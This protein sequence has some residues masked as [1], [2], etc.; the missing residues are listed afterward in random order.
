[1]AEPTPERGQPVR[2][3]IGGG[4][5]ALGIIAMIGAV[6]AAEGAFVGERQHRV[7]AVIVGSILM[8]P[9]GSWI[10]WGDRALTAQK[11]ALFAL[12]PMLMMLGVFEGIA[13]VIDAE[14]LLSPL[15]A[16]DPVLD[17]YM[18][19]GT[20]GLDDWGFRNKAVPERVDVVFLGDSMTYGFGV[21]RSETYPVAFAE[22]SS[23]SV[24]NM[25]VGAYGPVQYLALTER[26]L[27]LEPRTLVIGLYLGNDIIDA[28]RM[29]RFDHWA[30]LRD[31]KMDYPPGGSSIAVFSSGGRNLAARALIQ[32]E[33]GSKVL[34]LVTK[35]LRLLIRTNQMMANIHRV[36]EGAPA[37]AE[38]PLAT[39]FTTSY[40][41][42]ALDPA[43]DLVRDGLRITK[44]AFERIRDL[45][46][47]AGVQ[48]VV[49][50]IHTKEFIYTEFM[51]E[52]KQP[53]DGSMRS[54]GRLEAA[55]TAEI[56]TLTDELGLPLV[57]TAPSMIEALKVERTVY[58]ASSDGHPTAEGHRVLA[59]GLYARRD[60]WAGADD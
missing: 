48:L 57:E 26:A 28:F 30:E 3:K 51:R 42:A 23:L 38:G 25:G 9:L 33:R 49:M 20:A 18:I 36:E 16:P 19:P 43:S 60:L 5:I 47:A 59:E 44:I 31:P 35:Q 50:L 1:M 6:L 11:R 12:V 21:T 22:L 8:L 40:R 17:F 2:G 45:C 7:F 13:R 34:G 32:L 54:L 29:L 37:Y 27:S 24:Y 55:L 4:V 56:R 10:V 58:P 15:T 53:I 41:T 14:T 52:R 39:K 46:Q